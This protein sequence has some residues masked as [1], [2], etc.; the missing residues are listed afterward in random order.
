MVLKI[1]SSLNL[2]GVK[3]A[4]LF[5]TYF[6]SFFLS[7]NFSVCSKLSSWLL[8]GFFKWHPDCLCNYIKM[9]ESLCHSTELILYHR[10]SINEKHFLSKRNPEEQKTAKCW[11]QNSNTIYVWTSK[12]PGDAL[13]SNGLPLIA[14]SFICGN[15]L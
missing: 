13:V 15:I 6:Y 3:R 14:G 1:E 10:T 12:L 7:S 5:Q 8:E 4:L 9:T 11:S 2:L